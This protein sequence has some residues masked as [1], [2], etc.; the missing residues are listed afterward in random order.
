LLRIDLDAKLLPI[1]RRRDVGNA[2]LAIHG[3][4][5]ALSADE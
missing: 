5:S 3:T 1:V 2:M 4:R